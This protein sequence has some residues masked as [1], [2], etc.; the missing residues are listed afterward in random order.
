MSRKNA[1]GLPLIVLLF[2]SLSVACKNGNGTPHDC[3]LQL[4]I[5]GVSHPGTLLAG[6]TMEIQGSGFD[7]AC[8]QVEVVFSGY[9]GGRDV[10][11]VASPEV[12]SL[13]RLNL[14]ADS[15]FL[16]QFGSPGGSFSGNLGVRIAVASETANE[17]FYPVQFDIAAALSPILTD[18]SPVDVTLNAAVSV[19][20]DGLIRDGEGTTHAI[21]D[22]TFEP[23][24][25]GT[26]AISGARTAVL[27]VEENDRTRGYFLFIPS[28][29]G[30]VPG[31]F[32]GTVMLR[33]EHADSTVTGSGAIAASFNLGTGFVTGISPSRTSLGGVLTVEGAGFI[34]ATTEETMTLLIEGTAIPY[35]GDPAAVTD[36]ELIGNFVDGGHVTYD[37][38]PIVDTDTNDRL[39]A[40]DFGFQRGSFSGTVTPILSYRGDM[41]EGVPTHIDFE[42]GPVKQVVFVDFTHGFIDTLEL[43]GLRAVSLHVKERVIGKM[44]Q[45]YNGINVEF[46]TE[47]PVDYYPG[48]Y[49]AL[50][51]SGPDPNGIGLFGYDNTPGKDVW[52]LRLHDRIGGVNAETQED[53]HRGYGGVFIDS[54][55]CWS[56]DSPGIVVC[57]AGLDPE[58]QFDTIFDPVR[59]QEVVAGEYPGG[60]DA[61]R[62]AQIAEA[63]RVLGNIIGDTA[64]HELGHS[65]GLAHPYGATD[66][67]HN[68]PPGPGCL[69]DAGAYRPFDERAELHGDP[70]GTWCG[71]EWGY[72]QTIMPID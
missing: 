28:L 58:P 61:A 24:T 70:P 14:T 38:I 43:F 15:G 31:S 50:E 64:A 68:E 4:A 2:A 22:G 41:V 44:R 29:V 27:L 56:E 8:G 16:G 66:L 17:V 42:L 51:I 39:I 71:D 54:V 48:G 3:A 34:G 12:A 65:F 57:P 9:Y 37:V 20:G 10:E 18:V 5:S 47:E 40:A 19:S 63:I 60:S 6:S 53:G 62:V 69:M 55:L 36:L 49:A 32:T 59:N 35:G 46:R 52:N 23:E 30:I 45:I 67:V 1:A 33:N 11:V 21:L 13:N 72:L 26:I 7:S 25:G